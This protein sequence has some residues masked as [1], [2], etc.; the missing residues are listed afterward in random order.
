M[1]EYTI[2]AIISVVLSVY[3]DRKLKTNLLQKKEFWLFLIIIAGFKLLVNG[4]LTAHIV[5]YNPN[6]FLG[7]RIGTIPLEDFVFGFSMI[8][9]ACITWE[10]S[11]EKMKK[12]M[13]DKR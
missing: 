3:F 2:L 6:Y 10:K 13:K 4:Y 5:R 9:C 12:V 11:L 1:K 8:M 7:F